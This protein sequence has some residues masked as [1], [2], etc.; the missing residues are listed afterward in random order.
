MILVPYRGLAHPSPLSL[1]R[2]RCRAGGAVGELASQW[3]ASRRAPRTDRS[4]RSHAARSP[5]WASLAAMRSAASSSVVNF[6]A[7]PSALRNVDAHRA[8]V[9]LESEYRRYV[10]G[11]RHAARRDVRPEGA[12]ACSLRV[13]ARSRAPATA[14][15]KHGRFGMQHANTT[16]IEVPLPQSGHLSSTEITLTIV[17]MLLLRVVLLATGALRSTPARAHL[18]TE[19]MRVV[20]PQLRR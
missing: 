3:R 5:R 1:S 20:S 13:L 9:A 6:W 18:S 2:R 16:P 12:P 11:S 8:R 14:G 19:W 7:A 17:P 4:A 15:A 10:A